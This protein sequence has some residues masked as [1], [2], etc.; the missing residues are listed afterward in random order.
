LTPRNLIFIIV[1]FG[2]FIGL[3]IYEYRKRKSKKERLFIELCWATIGIAVIQFGMGYISNGK[4]DIAKHIYS[5][6]YIYACMLIVSLVYGVGL[7][8]NLI[9]KSKLTAK[10]HL[11]SKCE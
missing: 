9:N 10:L 6:N 11:P 3:S 1:F 2:C 8:C 4:A 5:F 7:L